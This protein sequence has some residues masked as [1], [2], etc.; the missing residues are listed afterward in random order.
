MSSIIKPASLLSQRSQALLARITNDTAFPGG[1]SAATIWKYMLMCFDTPRPSGKEHMLR[2]KIIQIAKNLNI[3]SNVDSAGNL[4]LRKPATKGYEDR[5]KVAIQAHLDMVCSKTDDSTHDFDTQGVTVDV[6]PDGAWLKAEGT[7]LGADDGIGV[8]AGLAMMEDSTAVHGPLECIFTVEEETTMAGAINL[9]TRPFLE[10]QAILNVDS[11]EDHKICV[12]C[13][14]GL[15]LRMFSKVERDA[16][17]ETEAA[18]N[19]SAWSAVSV[20]LA[21]LVGGHTGIDI[22]RGRA[23][24]IHIIARTLLTA[25]SAVAEDQDPALSVRLVSISGGNAANAIPRDAQAVVAV[26]EAATFRSLKSLAPDAPLSSG[27]VLGKGAAGFV[28]ALQEYFAGVVEDYALVEAKGRIGEG[29][30]GGY[31]GQDEDEAKAKEASLAQLTQSSAV[32]S[33]TMKLETSSTPVDANW[34]K[35]HRVIKA[36]NTFTILNLISAVP[37]GVMRW[38]PQVEGDVDT[39]NALSMIKLPATPPSSNEGAEG[40]QADGEDGGRHGACPEAGPAGDHFWLHCFFRSYSDYQLKEVSRKLRSIASLAGATVTEGFGY[41]N[42]WEPVLESALFKSTLAAHRQLFPTRPAPQVYSVHAGL[43]CG[44]IKQR[45]P[46]IHAVSIGPLSTCSFSPDLLFFLCVTCAT[47]RVSPTSLSLELASS[48]IPPLSFT[49]SVQ[50]LALTR[51]MRRFASTLFP[52]LW[53]GSVARLQTSRQ[54][55]LLTLARPLEGKSHCWRLMYAVKCRDTGHQ[56]HE[57]LSH[58]PTTATVSTCHANTFDYRVTCR[59][60]EMFWS[61]LSSSTFT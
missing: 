24:A 38:S 21:G 51:Q 7:T 45:Y 55:R 2:D 44:P 1:S 26:N 31:G 59:H 52:P 19:V 56:D 3:E 6:T 35:A 60:V 13:A 40:K 28:A 20:S 32:V 29:G 18:N 12:G 9:A 30:T 36:A 43:E 27:A 41:F 57:N 34:L 46:D 14:G 42:G 17:L 25:L 11:E 4:C 48:P 37:H 10:A 22:H 61:Q 47:C 39:S 54:S 49:S 53:T 58:P 16:A 15:E 5:V 50:S 23:N 8:A 33:C